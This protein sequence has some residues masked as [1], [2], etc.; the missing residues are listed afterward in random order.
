[1]KHIA[2]FCT[3]L[4]LSTPAFAGNGRPR[5]CYGIPW[6]G[7]WLRHEFG[8]SDKRYNLAHWWI[9]FGH[10]ISKPIVGAVAVF[11]FR[12]VGRVEGVDANG[13]PIVK[14]GNHNHRVETATYPKR[15]VW[16]YRAP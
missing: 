8:I 13:N 6:C 10:R 9:H 3:L 2:I 1:M 11:K 12:H 15:L 7:C 14:S 5:D 16:Q 4:M